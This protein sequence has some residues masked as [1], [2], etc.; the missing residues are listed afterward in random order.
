MTQAEAARKIA[1][2]EGDAQSAIHGAKGEAEANRI[3]LASLTPRCWNFVNWKI[4]ER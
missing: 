3:R 1:E 2:A 4:N